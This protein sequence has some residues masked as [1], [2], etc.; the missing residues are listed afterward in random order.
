[1]NIYRRKPYETVNEMTEWFSPLKL[2]DTHK[3]NTKRTLI[4][5]FTKKENKLNEWDK[6]FIILFRLFR[7]Y[8]FGTKTPEM[9]KYEFQ[10]RC[11]LSDNELNEMTYEEFVHLFAMIMPEIFENEEK[12]QKEYDERS[13]ESST[14]DGTSGGSKKKSHKRSTRNPRRSHRRRRR[15]GRTS[16]HKYKNSLYR[17]VYRR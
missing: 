2:E 13:R 6:F 14:K 9:Y 16:T 15:R 17:C 5:I 10:K 7:S 11:K 4:D 1:M 8:E 3:D 12:L